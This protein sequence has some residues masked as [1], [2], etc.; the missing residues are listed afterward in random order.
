M[1]NTWQTLVV[2]ETEHFQ[3]VKNHVPCSCSLLSILSSLL[4]EYQVLSL[5][6]GTVTNTPPPQANRLFSENFCVS[7]LEFNAH[8]M[9]EMW[10]R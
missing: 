6:Q 3:S 5:I 8:T 7:P 2:P 1:T 10:H 4:G 9:M